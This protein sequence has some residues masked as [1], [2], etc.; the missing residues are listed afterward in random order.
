MPQPFAD[1]HHQRKQR[2]NAPQQTK[3]KGVV[4]MSGH[5]RRTQFALYKRGY[6]QDNSQQEVEDANEAFHS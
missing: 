3:P 2:E 5:P 1:K 4:D 6:S